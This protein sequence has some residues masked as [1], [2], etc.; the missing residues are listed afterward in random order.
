M[1]TNSAHTTRFCL[2][3]PE[4]CWGGG[5]REREAEGRR[6]RVGREERLLWDVPVTCPKDRNRS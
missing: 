2:A 5:I 6:R 3:R 1:K 4:Q